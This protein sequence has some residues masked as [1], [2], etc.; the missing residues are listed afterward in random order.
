[1]Q[2]TVRT[3]TYDVNVV[4]KKREITR[5]GYKLKYRL[6]IPTNYDCGEKYPLMVFLHGA[7]ERGDDNEAQLKNGLQLMFNDITSPVYDS[8]II[9]PQCPEG[10]QWESTRRGRT[11]RI[12]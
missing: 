4:F 12:P 10:E 5:D 2:H 8:V 9:V 3:N 7:G 1:M 11:T 6:Y